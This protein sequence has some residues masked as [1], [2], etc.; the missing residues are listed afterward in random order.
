[1][2]VAV[3]SEYNSIYRVLLFSTLYPYK[4]QA[5]KPTYSWH[6]TKVHVIAYSAENQSKN[7]T[8][9]RVFEIFQPSDQ[10]NIRTQCQKIHSIQWI[11][12]VMIVTILRGCEFFGPGRCS[13]Q[14]IERKVVTNIV[15]I[16]YE[17]LRQTTAWVLY[18]RQIQF[19]LYDSRLQLLHKSGISHLLRQNPG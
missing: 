4:Q 17:Q 18:S 15:L 11:H 9:Y 8:R 16:C 7:N 12:C 6:I 3:V 19:L 13:C 1:M 14:S 5:C 2:L 10:K